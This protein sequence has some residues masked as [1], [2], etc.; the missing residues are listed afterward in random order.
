MI[1]T[2]HVQ[3]LTLQYYS[4]NGSVVVECTFAENSSA[5]GCHVIF[6][7]SSKGVNKPINISK[8][9][10]NESAACQYIILPVTGN[11]TVTVHDI[12]DG[13]VTTKPSIEDQVL[14]YNLP[15]PSPTD[16]T[17]IAISIGK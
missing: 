16:S 9:S 4:D 12:V 2:Y 1:E 17:E 7:E 6:R 15:L 3:R 8:F 5:D 11:Y 14:E 13:T 10:I